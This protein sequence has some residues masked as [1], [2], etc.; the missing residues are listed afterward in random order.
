MSFGKGIH[1]YNP[2]AVKLQNVTF[3]QGALLFLPRQSP[4]LC[5]DMAMALLNFPHHRL[6]LS[7]LALHINSHTLCTLLYQIFSLSKIYFRFICVVVWIS[8][9]LFIAEEYSMLLNMDTWA[10]FRFWWSWIKL[11]YTV[12]IL[13]IFG[14]MLFL[15][16]KCLPVELLVQRTVAYFNFITKMRGFPRESV[17]VDT[18]SKRCM[19]VPVV[20]ESLKLSL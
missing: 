20:L 4:A 1:L 14:Q 10:V 15:L 9:F 2:N 12:F 19:R 8:S 13:I 16:N 11:L 6:F 3:P 5:P 18:P 17:P 7:V